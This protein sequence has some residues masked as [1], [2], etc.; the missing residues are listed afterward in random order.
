[1]L[2]IE[3]SEINGE[4][5]YEIEYSHNST[6]MDIKKYLAD[7]MKSNK[8][9][10]IEDTISND[11]CAIDNINII[12]N[13]KVISESVPLNTLGEDDIIHFKFH[14]KHKEEIS[15]EIQMNPINIKNEVE[16]VVKETNKRIVVDKQKIIE[17]DG[18]FYLVTRRAPRLNLKKAILEAVNR[19][20]PEI[21][22]KLAVIGVLLLTRNYEFAILL[23]IVLIMRMTSVIPFKFNM[24]TNG[25]VEH[26]IK[27]FICFFLSMF[28]I[29][30]DKIL[31][32]EEDNLKVC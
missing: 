19:I 2:K 31:I 10:G 25:I 5:V 22:I 18:E 15:D 21:L 29:H 32:F 6:I 12:F 9:I 13:G 24:I 14:V 16:V 28:F 27:T 26:V 8:S 4:T 20:K 1:M 17:K 7:K 3:L 30:C 11:E 23:I